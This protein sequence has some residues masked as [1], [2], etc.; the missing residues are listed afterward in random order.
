MGIGPSAA[1]PTTVPAPVPTAPP[2]AATLTT[3]PA[4][5][6]APSIG[7][8]IPSPATASPPTPLARS[9]G[10][11]TATRPPPSALTAGRPAVA[12]AASL[13]RYLARLLDD[14]R[15]DNLIILQQL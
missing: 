8:C 9:A 15:D 14:T 12:A 10:V 11:Q 5:I 3:P 1:T 13:H 7:I 4:A 6:P 2:T